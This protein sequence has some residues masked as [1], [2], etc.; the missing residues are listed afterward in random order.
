MTLGLQQTPD[1]YRIEVSRRIDASRDV[2]WNL[3]TDTT[4]WP[5]WGPTIENVDCRDRYIQRGTRGRIRV[6]GGPGGVW[7]PFR[8]TSCAD[9]RWSWTV[10]PPSFG[11][12]D[13]APHIQVTGHRVERLSDSGRENEQGIE[14]TQETNSCCIIFELPPLA[15]GYAVV[16]DRALIKL[17]RIAAREI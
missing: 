7:L 11:A 8:I 14:H 6:T 5:D 17:D 3:L 16:C 9:Y 13:P 1:G 10:G 2:L 12:F 4:R 15:A